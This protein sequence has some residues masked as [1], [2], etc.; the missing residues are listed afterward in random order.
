MSIN[1]IK[2][3]KLIAPKISSSQC[4]KHCIASEAVHCVASGIVEVHKMVVY[5]MIL[6]T[7]TI[8]SNSHELTMPFRHRGKLSIVIPLWVIQL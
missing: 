1:S 4:T 2:K 5:P 7:A 3:L 8:H 6:I